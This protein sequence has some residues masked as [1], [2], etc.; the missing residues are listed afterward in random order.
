V[1]YEVILPTVHTQEYTPNDPKV[2]PMPRVDSNLRTC[3]RE[4]VSIR[5]GLKFY[6]R[7]NVLTEFPRRLACVHNVAKI[8]LQ[9]PSREGVDRKLDFISDFCSC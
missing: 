5:A 8:S 3:P 6:E 4:K 9:Y 7:K 1:E 2:A